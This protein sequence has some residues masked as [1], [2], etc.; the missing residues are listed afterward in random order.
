M[1]PRVTNE[2]VAIGVVTESLDRLSRGTNKSGQSG[3]PK[4]D[5]ERLRAAIYATRGDQY[6]DLSQILHDHLFSKHPFTPIAYKEDLDRLWFDYRSEELMFVPSTHK[7]REVYAQGLIKAINESL[8]SGESDPSPI[9]SY[10]LAN[11]NNFELLVFRKPRFRDG[12]DVAEQEPQY[13]FKQDDPDVVTLLIC[14]PPATYSRDR[15]AM[16]ACMV[17]GTK[18][19]ADGVAIAQ[20]TR[21]IEGGAE[22]EDPFAHGELN[23]A[24]VC[25]H[26]MAG[27][28]GKPK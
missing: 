28:V 13:S 11:S 7:P 18:Y 25:T 16:A 23:T 19:V 14:T 6:K 12:F 1:G 24:R 5:L 15:N 10:W 21:F 2:T 8:T 17:W 3:D 27:G 9:N 26:L 4:T 20:E 22:A